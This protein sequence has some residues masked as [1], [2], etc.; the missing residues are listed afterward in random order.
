MKPSASLP[1]CGLDKEL[2]AWLSEDFGKYRPYIDKD[3]V[4]VEMAVDELLE[5]F[6]AEVEKKKALK[7]A[8][9]MEASGD[10]K[11]LKAII[12][13]AEQVINVFKAALKRL[14]SS[15]TRL[16]L[17]ISSVYG[18]PYREVG[19]L[20]WDEFEVMLDGLTKEA[21]RQQMPTAQLTWLVAAVSGNKSELSSWFTGYAREREA[22]QR[23]NGVP[24]HLQRALETGIVLG[25]V[26]DAAF[27]TVRTV[28]D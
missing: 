2:P 15:G 16:K 24:E 7:M 17:S 12:Q 18:V 8:K 25:T 10:V 14:E 22:E 1:V 11:K 20:Y 5:P 23:D 13:S 3:Y 28:R 26:S 9:A 21:Q 4:S 27:S 6:S 19:K